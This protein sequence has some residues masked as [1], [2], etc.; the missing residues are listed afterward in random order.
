MQFISY[1]RDEGIPANRV[2]DA[3]ELSKYILERYDLHIATKDA[4]ELWQQ[5][6]LDLGV[7]WLPI[8]LGK[9]LV[10][11]AINHYCRL[12]DPTTYYDNNNS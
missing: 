1:E 3:L 11:P 5:V 8:G 10:L 4:Y 7:A 12:V 6:S 2:E 9:D